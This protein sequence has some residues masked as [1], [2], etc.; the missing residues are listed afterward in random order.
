MDPSK[1]SAKAT[2]GGVFPPKNKAL[3]VIPDSPA[4]SRR[5]LITVDTVQEV[6]SQSSLLLT[7]SG[8]TFPP[9]ASAAV[10]VPH[11][12][13]IYLPVFKFHTSLH[14]DPF[15]DYVSA[16]TPG[17]YPPNPKPAVCIPAPPID[18]RAVPKSAA[19]VQQV[20]F[21]DSLLAVLAGP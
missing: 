18:C 12:A 15:H 9:V 5:V 7:V 19:S 8:G 20:P 21:Q 3:V 10:F 11:P 14:A 13:R 2:V 4:P 17:S 16:L 1:N 6:P